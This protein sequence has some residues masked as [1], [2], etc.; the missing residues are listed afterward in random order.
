MLDQ[1]GE[2][3]EMLNKQ[4]IKNTVGAYPVVLS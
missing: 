1:E 4:E 2:Y 3:S